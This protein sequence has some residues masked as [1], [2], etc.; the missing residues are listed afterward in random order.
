[1]FFKTSSRTIDSMESGFTSEDMPAQ[2]PPTFT[3]KRLFAVGAGL[4]GLAGCVATALHASAPSRGGVQPVPA[5]TV[6]ARSLLEHPDFIDTAAQN[7]QTLVGDRL[8][9]REHKLRPAIRRTMSKVTE[10]LSK[11]DPEGGR[12]LE[13]IKL[14]HQQKDD[15]LGVVKRMSDKHV[16]NVGKKVLEIALSH[17]SDKENAM[18]GIQRDISSAFHPRM[19]ELKT[20][21]NSVMPASIRGIEEKFSVDHTEATPV[22]ERRLCTGDTSKCHPGSEITA[23]MSK[24]TDMKLEDAAG[25][26]GGVLEQAR[27]ALDE[28]ATI[29]SAFGSKAH[30]PYYWRS[31]IAGLDYAVEVGDC[32][33][34]QNDK[35]VKDANGQTHI[36]DSGSPNPVKSEMCLMKY[37]GAGMDFLA[38]MN[39]ALGIQNS[40]L[41]QDFQMMFGGAAPP[42]AQAGYSPYA[43]Q[44]AAPVPVQQQPPNPFAMFAPHQQPAAAHP[45]PTAQSVLNT[46]AQHAHTSAAAARAAHPKFAYAR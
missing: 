3:G 6:S 1:M 11:H 37:A 38:G 33:M 39:N 22:K 9:G 26:I 42:A 15:V 36:V 7:V 40:R 46:L 24:D 21:K 23:A 30:V 28:S 8:K 44:Q 10:L 2:P 41:P 13:A 4:L 17:Q 5:E 20:L 31:G 12:Q 34:R 35:H 16:Q 18:E 27:L 14:T 29:G 19:K 32:L 45:V 25:I 43:Q